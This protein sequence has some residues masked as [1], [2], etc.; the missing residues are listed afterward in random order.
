MGGNMAHFF[1]HLK[2]VILVEFFY[3]KIIQNNSW[4]DFL[5]KH[6]VLHFPLFVF[7]KILFFFSLPFHPPDITENFQALENG[8]ILI[9]KVI[10]K[11]IDTDFAKS[12]RIYV[13]FVNLHYVCNLIRM[14]MLVLNTSILLQQLCGF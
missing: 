13:N 5:C 7:L 3:S 2:F 8:H 10:K 6:N 14:H 1:L 4:L 11:G 9:S 12:F